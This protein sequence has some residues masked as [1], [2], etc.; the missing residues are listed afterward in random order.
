MENLGLLFSLLPGLLTYIVV[1][2][3]TARER[4]LD[5]VEAVLHGLA[6][7]VLVHSLWELL[8]L[9]SWIPTPDLAGLSLCSLVIGLTIAKC[10]SRG[11]IYNLL[12]R[13]GLTE[14]STW[15]SAWETSFRMARADGREYA[16]LYLKDGRR[17]M[18][19]VRGFSSEQNAGHVAIDR[20]Q[21]LSE[22]N[23]A[24]VIPGLMLLSANEILS[25]QFLDPK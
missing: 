5:A 16:V 3:L 1:R 24:T 23:E 22:K 25:V 17:I 12:R 18:G 20:S 4:K 21:W 7:T 19:A 13:F 10:H 8:T 6:Y 15:Q 11:W 14:E 2:A 9:K